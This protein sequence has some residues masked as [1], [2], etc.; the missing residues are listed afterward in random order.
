MKGQFPSCHGE[1]SGNRNKNGQLYI[2]STKGGRFTIHGFLLLIICII[3]PLYKKGEKMKTMIKK[4]RCCLFAITVLSLTAYSL[5]F[6]VDMKDGD[7]VNGDGSAESPFQHIHK[8]ISLTPVRTCDD[9]NSDTV[10]C[11]D[12]TY[13]EEQ[14]CWPHDGQDKHII[15]RSESA[16]YRKVIIKPLTVW[17]NNYH[18]RAYFWGA[19]NIINTSDGAFWM[20]YDVTIIFD[21]NNI[22]TDITDIDTVCLINYLSWQGE[23]PG[24]IVR[25][26]FDVV[27]SDKNI[28]AVTSLDA[29]AKVYKS[30]FRHLEAAVSGSQC[31]VY[32]NIFEGNSVAL[33]SGTFNE[34]YNCFFMNSVDRLDGVP[35]AGSDMTS[36]PLFIESNSAALEE[37]SECI[38]AGIQI[39]S[40]VEDFF[41]TAPDIG[42]YEKDADIAVSEFIIKKAVIG[43]HMNSQFDNIVLNALITL[44]ENNNGID[45]V[46]EVV[47]VTFGGFKRIIPAFSFIRSRCGAFTFISHDN[48]T[49][50]FIRIQRLHNNTLMFKLNAFGVSMNESV[51]PITT[52]IRIG[53]DTANRTFK[54]TGRLT[55]M[56]SWHFGH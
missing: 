50:L 33:G 37:N 20:I 6:Y 11:R 4:C 10:I 26:Y 48:G 34:G 8:A 45:P 3:I 16:D 32:D 29:P 53:D 1:K 36:D 30:T 14:T 31:E 42:A 54:L 13:N 12:G 7:D 19:C 43:Y 25:C 51:N 9:L 28:R 52:V 15:I 44:G 55:R 24:E 22:I 38:E 46:N 35:L 2:V 56:E 21:G 23:N 18:N 41:G 5:T 47:E 27:N 39:P 17:L 49:Q 40:Y